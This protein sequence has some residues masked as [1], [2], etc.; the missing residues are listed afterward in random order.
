MQGPVQP[1]PGRRA[2]DPD[3]MSGQDSG[4]LK[5]WQR[6]TWFGPTPPDSNPFDE[7][8]D[9]PELLEERSD[10][11]SNRSGSFWNEQ[12]QTGYQY[13]T[14]QLKKQS[15]SEGAAGRSPGKKDHRV[16]LR[17]ALITAAFLMAAIL[18]VYFGVFRIREIRVIGNSSIS[19]ADV[20]R[21]SGIRKGGSIL[22]LSEKETEE[23]LNASAVSAAMEQG[24]Y[25]YLRLQFR[26]LEKELP[27]TVI[28][29]VR[30]REACCFLTWC[31]ILYVMDKSGMVLYETEDTGMRDRMELV[32]VKGLEIRSGA[33]VGQTMVLSS[34]AQETVFKDLFLEMKVLGCTGQIREVDLSNTASILLSTRNGL[35]V[36]MGNGQSLHAK[37]RSLL[38][39]QEKLA[40]M[41]Q[42]GG[43][44]NVSNPETPSYSPPSSP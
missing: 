41:G 35:T 29:A 17:A 21:F 24:N 12:E 9:S 25:N 1:N 27:G 39:V 34:A 20:I 4:G 19:A 8:E 16:S 32:E 5:D 43:T 18:V 40:E 7:P 42:S 23:C 6:N 44:L 2:G 10:N 28:L 36:A 22:L 38:L 14:E 3:G 11:V 26:Y 13:S 15:A 33:H 31:G 30:E 37:L